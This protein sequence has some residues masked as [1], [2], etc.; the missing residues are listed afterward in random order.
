MRGNNSCTVC[1]FEMKLS[2]SRFV[3][4][5]AVE[6]TSLVVKGRGGVVQVSVETSNTLCGLFFLKIPGGS[7]ASSACFVSI[8]LVSYTILPQCH[9]KCNLATT[10]SFQPPSLFCFIVAHRKQSSS[11]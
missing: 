2:I 9:N 8:I 10:L 3:G 7:F 4:L 6:R 1:N 5:I 11:C